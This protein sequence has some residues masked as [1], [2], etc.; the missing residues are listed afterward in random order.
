MY[1]HQKHWARRVFD[2]NH[3]A[4]PRYVRAVRLV[5]VEIGLDGKS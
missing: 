3:N 5:C 4:N 1:D 2:V